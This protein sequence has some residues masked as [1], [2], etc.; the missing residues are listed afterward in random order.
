[1]IIAS[2]L[3]IGTFTIPKGWIEGQSHWPC[4]VNVPESTL[5][6]D[7]LVLIATMTLRKEDH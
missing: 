4:K 3:T 6:K 1:M 7:K 2:H 5:A